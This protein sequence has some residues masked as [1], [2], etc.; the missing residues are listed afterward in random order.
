MNA[1]APAST[2]VHASTVAIGG[3]AVLISGPPGCGKSDLAL[4]LI[5]RGARL[6]A[7]DQ[8]E[9][10]LCADG[11]LAARAP[12]TIAGNIEVRGLGLVSVPGAAAPEETFPV[13]LAVSVE[14][15]TSAVER[16]P[17]P[18]TAEILGAAVP[19]VAVFGF[20]ASAAVVVETALAAVRGVRTWVHG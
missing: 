18:E 12:A 20:A 17:E 5:D 7:D 10:D 15:S 14:T 8:T 1:S 2:V 4:R 11:T 19:V 9:V 3:L 13:A 6:V 16:L